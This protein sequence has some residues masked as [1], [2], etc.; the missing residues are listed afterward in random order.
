M[1]LRHDG[2]V[3]VC[4]AAADRATPLY[5]PWAKGIKRREFSS[6]PGL[7]GNVGRGRICYNRPDPRRDVKG[8]DRLI[9]C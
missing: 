2:S 3:T 4:R 9:S 7:V 5:A 8:G 1:K 6:Q